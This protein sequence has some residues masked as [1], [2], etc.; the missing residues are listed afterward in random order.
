MIPLKLYDLLFVQKKLEVNKVNPNRPNINYKIKIIKNKNSKEFLFPFSY[1]Y[2]IF[3][4][5]FL[6]L[7]KTF[8]NLFNKGFIRANNSPII[9]P[10]LFVKKL[11]RR[12][13]FYYNYC[14]LNT[15]IKVNYY[16]LPLIKE[17]FKVITKAKQFTKIDII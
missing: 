14:T 12:L 11:N 13:Y 1:F 17:T 7:K 10:V 4:K 2:N 9:I 8:K 5:E 15:I 6:I 16:F 3:K